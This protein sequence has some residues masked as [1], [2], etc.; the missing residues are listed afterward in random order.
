[1]C[2]MIGKITYSADSATINFSFLDSAI[3]TCA[4]INRLLTVDWVELVE[5]GV[6]VITSDLAIFVVVFSAQLTANERRS[7]REQHD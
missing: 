1:M 5:V 2:E 7:N 4:E 3:H 6:K